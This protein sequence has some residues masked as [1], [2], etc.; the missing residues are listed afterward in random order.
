MLRSAQFLHIFCEQ[1]VENLSILVAAMAF[2]LKATAF[3]DAY[4]VITTRLGGP[5]D[6][7]IATTYKLSQKI[8]DRMVVDDMQ[9][10]DV[11][12][13]A[14]LS[15]YAAD[16]RSAANRKKIPLIKLVPLMNKLWWIRMD[17]EQNEWSMERA[18]TE[19][20]AQEVYDEFDRLSLENKIDASYNATAS[21]VDA[22]FTLHVSNG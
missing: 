9:N 13:Q 15:K 7:Q 5:L 20:Q 14:Q 12:A 22:L 21:V 19:D 4:N 2:A 6:V 8:G 11:D 16:I 3:Q 1:D 17:S 10:Q 18:E